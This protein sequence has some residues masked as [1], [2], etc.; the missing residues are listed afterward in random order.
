MASNSLATSSAWLPFRPVP[1]KS[2]RNSSSSKHETPP[3]TIRSLGRFIAFMRTKKALCVV[4][5][6]FKFVVDSESKAG[7][8]VREA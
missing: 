8:V 7:H 2:A 6:A 5:K 1:N 4:H 3:S